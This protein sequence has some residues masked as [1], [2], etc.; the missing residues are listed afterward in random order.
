MDSELIKGT[1]SFLILSLLARK[2]MYGYQIASTIKE[3][4]NG[5]LLWKE[6]TLY[7]NLH[8]LEKDGL[9]RARWEGAPG[10]RRRKYY[11]ITQVG[12]DSLPGKK[13]VWAKLCE[14]VNVVLERSNETD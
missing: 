5:V 14:A 10:T 7:P 6:G 13:Q 3:Q 2:P 11:H 9:L 1:I 8:K 12:L 4:T